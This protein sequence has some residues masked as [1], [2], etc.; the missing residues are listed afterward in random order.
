[1]FFEGADDPNAVPF[2]EINATYTYAPTELRDSPW[3][4]SIEIDTTLIDLLSITVSLTPWTEPNTG[5]VYN[6]IDNRTLGCG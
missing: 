5:I 1:M 2:Q 4:P 3:Q 6:H